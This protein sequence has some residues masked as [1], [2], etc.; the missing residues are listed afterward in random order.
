MVGKDDTT[1]WTGLVCPEC[2]EPAVAWTGLV[3]PECGEPAVA[4]PPWLWPTGLGPCPRASHGD[5]EPLCPV[6]GGAG[7]EPATPV[8]ARG[9][10]R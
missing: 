2:G 7:Y 5:G 9:G 1:G 6:V 3:C 10:A 4:R 8:R